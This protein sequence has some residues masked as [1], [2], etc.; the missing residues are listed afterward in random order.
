[1]PDLPI[2]TVTFL[3]TD[4]A[5]SSNLWEQQPNT[6]SE[7]LPRHDAML[8]EAIESRQGVVFKTVGDGSH[9]VFGN[10]SDALAAAVAAQRAILAEPWETAAPLRIRVALHTGVAELRGGDYFGSPL[11]RTARLLAAAHGGQIL[12]SLVTTELVRDQLPPDLA[13]RDLGVHRLR[14]LTRPEQ[15]FQ[16]VAPDLPADFSPL[17]TLD[18]RRHNL[19]AQPSALIGR[20]WEVTNICALLSRDDVGL[21]TLTG[22]GGAG[23]T[24]LALHVAAELL[25]QF[26]DGVY[27][28]ALAPISDPDLVVPAIAQTLGVR[29]AGE[30]AI[31]DQLKQYIAGKLRLLVLDNF[32]QVLESALLVKD[33]LTAAPMIKILVTSRAALRLSGEHEFSVPPLTLP[34][35]VHLPP[36]DR[37]I[38]YEAVRIFVER[39]QAVRSDFTITDANAPAV[40]EIC[41]RLDGLPLAIEL[42]A[43]RSKLFAPAALLE[44]LSSPLALLT[45]GPRDLPARQ[46]TLRATIEWSYNLLPARERTLFTRM[47]AFVGGC[48]LDAVE[49]VCAGTA[50]LEPGV[51]AAAPVPI[52]ESVEA[53]L[54][55]NLLRQIEGAD[56]EPR[57]VMLETIHQYARDRWSTNGATHAL[58]Q[59][60]ADYFLGLAELADSMLRGPEQGMWLARLEAE[61]D[62]LRA[63]LEWYKTADPERCLRLAG[64]LW[65][66]WE[67]HSH[68]SEGR[69]WLR[70]VLQMQ[71]SATVAARARALNGAGVLAYL[72]GDYQNASAFL[73]AGLDLFR[74]LHDNTGAAH[75]LRSLG[76]V[77]WFQG[78]HG[79]ARM[80]LE[81]SA[82]LFREVPYTWGIAD[83]LHWLGHVML[84]QDDGALAGALFEESLAL[85]RTT[86]DNRNIALPLKDIG[87]I[88]SLRGDAATAGA[89]YEESLSLSRA[90]DDTWHIA[91]TLQRLGD[92]ARRDG[93]YQRAAT[94]CQE[95]LELWRKLGNNGGIAEALNLLGEV[96]Q[97]QGAYRQAIA[98]YS[99]SLA[100][101]R[102]IGSK[103]V[104]AGVLHNLGK[105][106][107]YDNDHEQAAALYRESLALNSEIEY[108]PGIADCLVGL[109]AVAAANGSAE[110][111]AQLLGAAEPHLDSMR[112]Y[113]PLTDRGNYTHTLAEVRA[114]LDPAAFA[115][116]FAQGHALQLGQ[117]IMYAQDQPRLH[118]QGTPM[119]QPAAS[120]APAAYPAGLTERE[121]AVLR[122]VA[123]GLTDAQVAE[124]LVISRRTVNGHLRSIYGKLG[125]SSRTAA[126]HFAVTHQLV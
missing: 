62:N 111:A 112:G 104:I 57:L 83:A 101:L 46:Q 31:V 115:A 47:A 73:Q 125:V 55:Q 52:L 17:N 42:A 38:H 116:A 102:G 120:A 9:A 22:P 85:F 3:F 80:Q 29:E 68:L 44:R 48:T 109:A 4:I 118:E 108:K 91:E 95:G 113:M 27:C 12:L 18:Q 82:A 106:A 6:M 70:A 100:L 76:L 13:L 121:V 87:L 123:Q 56:D 90:V 15:I 61:H 33:L 114:Q 20:E 51:G 53:L 25:D 99:E 58:R 124:R 34:D 107:Q 21:V 49:A 14:D 89:L 45:S 16:L 63:A 32:E 72:Q 36:R 119:P 77:A 74:D 37:L 105:V 122:L 96:A 1:M 92:L 110:R 86:G 2:G 11:N 7:A 117:A 19:P 41:H 93:D 65:H 8:R 75:I 126:V 69:A 88:A 54:N 24:R 50:G 59:R 81:A 64:A 10:A 30:R 98:F 103:R 5:G 35:R 40:V 78:D 60:H 43:A 97:L 39:A 94:I 26:S 71:A 67:M 84:E 79:T 28:V 23:K 66:F